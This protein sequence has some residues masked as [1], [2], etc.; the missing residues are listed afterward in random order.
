MIIFSFQ[1][2]I[3]PDASS[4]G[5]RNTF[6]LPKHK[7]PGL[8]ENSSHIDKLFGRRTSTIGLL[9]GIPEELKACL[10][11]VTRK[12][13]PGELARGHLTANADFNTIPEREATF[14][15]LNAAPQ[16]Q[17]TNN[18]NY[19][20]VEQFARDFVTRIGQPLDVYTG[21]HGRDKVCVY[22]VEYSKTQII[23]SGHSYDRWFQFRSEETCTDEDS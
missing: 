7:P 15:Y 16:W 10:E 3:I 14:Y 6:K 2:P 9:S 5:R 11:E 22:Y 19:K 21:T 23:I 17:I 1:K 13:H 18:G 20:I 4:N 12:E 8:I